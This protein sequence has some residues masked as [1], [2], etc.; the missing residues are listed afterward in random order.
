MYILEFSLHIVIL[1]AIPKWEGN[2]MKKIRPYRKLTTITVVALCLFL[3]ALGARLNILDFAP[4]FNMENPM[5]KFI[6]RYTIDVDFDPVEKIITGSETVMYV[7]NTGM[8]LDAVYFHLYPNAFKNEKY[9]PF[10]KNEMN[11]AYPDGF[12]PGYIKIYKVANGKEPLN[13]VTMG[14]GETILKVHLNEKLDMG[15]TV[16]INIDFQV[17]IPPSR[18][19][20]GYGENTVN[21]GNWYPIASVFDQQGWNLEPYYSIGD[22][23]Y[24]DTGD[25]RIGIALPREYILATTGDVIKKEEIEGK[26]LWT[27]E[28]KKVR[29]FSMVISEKY[30]I[31]TDEVDGIKVHSY[32]INEDFGEISLEAA[33][34]S[35]KIFNRLFGEYP[36][37][38]F[39][40][41][42]ADFFVGG[43]E[44]PNLVYIDN[45]LYSEE[46]KDILE[47][48]IVHEA[49]HQWWYGVVG[50][51]QVDESWLDEALT[52][53]STL[54]Y[55]EMKYGPE[56]KENIYKNMMEKYYN[57][58]MNGNPNNDNKVYKSLKE[59]NSPLEY[60]VMVYYK[61][62]MFVKE[63]RKQLGD[64]EFFQI[65]KVYF[66]KY[67]YKNATTE[68][69]IEV[70]EKVTNRQLKGLFEEWLSYKKE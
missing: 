30:K 28:G 26:V 2:L 64:E 61:G 55:Y 36:Y 13:Y 14:L 53:Y 33:R 63:L 29:D 38:Q 65:M 70:C 15:Q 41:A 43:M 69:F 67:K 66:D 11:L 34:D 7:N 1:A 51:D 20:F 35:I 60:Q 9:L 54:L 44:Y 31:L 10:E 47:Y 24:S 46:D 32:Y 37:K 40:V 16:E 39:N 4:V 5:G 57:A 56:V 59:F 52:E 22:P 48:V 50:N 68:D 27:I 8:E 45:S 6:N 19:R 12:E 62:A 49:A 42:A 18:G 25:Y 23:F 58:Y 17:K 3:S 21:M